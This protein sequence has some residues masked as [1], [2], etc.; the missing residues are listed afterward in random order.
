MIVKIIQ[1]SGNED[2]DRTVER[3]LSTVKDVPPFRE[4]VSEDS[5]RYKLSFNLKTKKSTD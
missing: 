3:A 1:A 2:F 4:E 5:L